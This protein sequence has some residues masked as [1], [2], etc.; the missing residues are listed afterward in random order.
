MSCPLAPGVAD[1]AD[2]LAQEVGGAADG[3]GA[4]LA[5]AGHEHVAGAGRDREQ[6][7]IAAHVGVAVVE[8]ALLLEAVGL[9]DRRVE[10]DGQRSV[11][12]S[13][14]RRPGPREQLPADPVELAHV[15]PAE[16]AQERAQRGGRLDREAQ[17]PGRA[18]GPQ[19]VRVVDAVATRERR[20]DERQ[21]LVAD[22]GAA[23]LVA[24]VEVLVDEPLQAQVVGQ[25]GRQQEARIGHQAVVV[26]G[27]VE[28]VEAVR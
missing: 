27:R 18:A 1:P 23:G 24:Q 3:V 12:G 9:A 17:D 28:A 11:A 15:A 13:G 22:V 20:H 16:A 21:Q 6:R 5:Q 14:T 10:V 19:R 2:R 26:E 7:V 4:A 8:G 25:R